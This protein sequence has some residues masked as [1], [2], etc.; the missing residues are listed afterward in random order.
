MWSTVKML[1]GFLWNRTENM[2]KLLEKIPSSSYPESKAQCPLGELVRRVNQDNFY[3]VWDK[4]LEALS[5]QVV[6]HISLVEVFCGGSRKK[7]CFF[8]GD[9]TMVSY[10]RQ[11]FE[12]EEI[13]CAYITPFFSIVSCD[14]ANCSHNVFKNYMNS[15]FLP[16]FSAMSEKKTSSYKCDSCFFY[17]EK[18]H[19]CKRCLTKMYC[20]KECQLKD[21]KKVHEKICKDGESER[22]LKSD[23]KTRRRECVAKKEEH[24]ANM[25][26]GICPG[27][28][29]CRICLPPV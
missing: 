11:E 22:K 12:A 4:I 21:W 13:K 23:G 2:A 16:A 18:P 14:K 28:P 27:P 15:F 25:G 6:A 10:V 17:S 26:P 7:D 8:C 1:Y 3:S 20:S 5:E 9:Q 19:R 29:T 24:E